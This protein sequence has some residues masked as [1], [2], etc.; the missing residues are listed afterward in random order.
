MQRI[1]GVDLARGLAVIGMITAHV[2]PGDASD[3]FPASLAQVVDGRSAAL[4]VLLSG[5]SV[6]LMSG[7][8]T[9][10]VGTRRVQVRT[11][12]LVRALLVLGIGALTLVLGTPI[13][14]ILP[15]YAVLFAVAT[16]VLGAGPRRL[17]VAAAV[18]AVA[19]P[20]VHL[21]LQPAFALRPGRAYTDLLLG[22]YYPAVVWVAYVLVGLAVGRLELR[23]SR[24]RAW[25]LAVGTVLALLGHGT[26][27][28]LTRAVGPSSPLLALVTSEPHSS[29]TLEVVANTGVALGLLAICLW[30]GD[31]VPRLTA[32][33]AA[34]GS[35]ALTAYVGHLLAIAAL[36]TSVVWEPR[37]SVWLAFLLVTMGGCW[38]WRSMWGRGPLER[39]LHGVAARA[40]D[41]SPDAL[42][43]ARTP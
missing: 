23:S 43:P 25:L 15:T 29:T 3:P 13:A 9:P 27:A 20:L 36:G 5:L 37:T 22:D 39:L 28:L 32:P 1:T 42:P 10:V 38:L 24:V 34:T 12:L 17:L 6:A 8:A 16:A 7:G 11:R 41:V 40:S 30:L 26:A 18:V 4:F 35:L 19:G 33:L 14:V 2:G 21:A 31:R